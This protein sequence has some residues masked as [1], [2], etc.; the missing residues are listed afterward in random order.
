MFIPNFF[1]TNNMTK[2]PI[3]IIIREIPIDNQN[4]TFFFNKI[5]K[6][7]KKTNDGITNQK[8]PCDNSA[9]LAVSFVSIYIH[10]KASNDTN[11]TDARILPMV[12]L[13]LDI[14]EIATKVTDD[15]N[16]LII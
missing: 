3:T 2:Y 15:N 10:T 5:G 12:V 4:S 13:R 16:T 6:R 1:K 11:G 8:I 7:I 14:S 9:I